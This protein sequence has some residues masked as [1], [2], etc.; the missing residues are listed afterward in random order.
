MIIFVVII[1]IMLIRNYNLYFLQYKL[2][3]IWCHHYVL[4][5]NVHNK[6][7]MNFMLLSSLFFSNKK[8]RNVSF[9]IECSEINYIFVIDNNSF[10]YFDFET[11]II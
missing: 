8:K 1:K 9:L 4:C 11:T 3:H 7:K 5:I 10:S 6:R 2:N